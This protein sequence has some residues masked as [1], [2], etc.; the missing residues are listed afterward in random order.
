VISWV[1]IGSINTQTWRVWILAS[2]D[3]DQDTLDAF[4][5][6][7]GNEDKSGKVVFNNG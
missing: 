5:A 6:M 4:V 7:G 1:F 3:D 2:V